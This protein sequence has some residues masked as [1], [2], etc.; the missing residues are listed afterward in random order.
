MPSDISTAG[1]CHSVD[2][3]LELLTQ[4]S[5]HPLQNH[6]GAFPYPCVPGLT[7]L[8]S[9]GAAM[10][11][12]GLAHW[13]PS[14]GAGLLVTLLVLLPLALHVQRSS[15]VTSLCFEGVGRRKAAA[16]LLPPKDLHPQRPLHKVLV[17][18]QAERLTSWLHC[19][20]RLAACAAAR[21]GGGGGSH[22]HH[23]GKVQ[24]ELA[25]SRWVAVKCRT[26]L[27]LRR[28]KPAKGPGSTPK[29]SLHSSGS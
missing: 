16:G 21:G 18:G 1:A 2:H 10:S 6:G 4:A 24:G 22:G 17:H 14:R 15:E 11:K 13:L 3:N 12:V 28:H 25:P 5:Q 19:R 29:N 27:Q 26:P 7:A 8:H 9:Q 20:V 23:A